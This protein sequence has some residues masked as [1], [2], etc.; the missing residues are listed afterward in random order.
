[1]VLVVSLFYSM[2]AGIDRHRPYRC[3]AGPPPP[4]GRHSL[5]LLVQG[6]YQE[7]P[8]GLDYHPLEGSIG[9][10]TSMNIRLSKGLEEEGCMLHKPD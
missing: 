10:W 7:M 6:W 4:H 2:S 1:M 5:S 8:A 9:R 3:F